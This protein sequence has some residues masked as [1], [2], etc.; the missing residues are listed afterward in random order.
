LK[1]SKHPYWLW[2]KFN[3]TT[4]SFVIRHALLVYMLA[5]FHRIWNV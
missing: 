4:F 2:V 5:V 1:I 3:S